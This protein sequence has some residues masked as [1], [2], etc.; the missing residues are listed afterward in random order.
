MTAPYR[1]D[2]PTRAATA[3]H[4]RRAGA[5]DPA[6]SGRSRSLAR[7]P[8]SFPNI[9]I[10]VVTVVWNYGGLSADEMASRIVVDFERGAD[11]DGQR[12]RAHRV[13]VAARHR[14]RQG[15]LPA[16]REHR[17]GDRAGHRDRRS[18]SCGSCRPAPRRR[19]SS[20]TTPRACRS[21][22]S[23]L[24]GNGLSEQQLFDLGVNFLRTQLATVQGAPIPFPTAAS[25][26]QIQVDL[27]PRALQAKGL[28]PA[29]VVNAISAQNLILPAGH[30][31]DRRAS[32]TTCD[33]TAAR[34]RST[35]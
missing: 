30:R 8:T 24:S 25:S 13:A 6:A 23:A 12:H 34:R 29:D 31:E 35:S 21:C 19:S 32:S 5:A 17:R 20:S 1:V 3:L 10:P 7:R 26:A 18:R 14:G 33:S 27:D 4:V 28:S 16:G 2:R 15:L 11:D 9:D 22:S